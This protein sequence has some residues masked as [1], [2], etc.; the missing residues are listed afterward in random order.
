MRMRIVP[1]LLLLMAV[2]PPSI[3]ARADDWTS[4]KE[5][6]KSA[7]DFASST[8]QLKKTIKDVDENSPLVM[9]I[10][11]LSKLAAQ[12]DD[13]VAKGAVYED[14]KKDFRKIE[15]GYA[16]FEAGLKKDHDIHH[17]IPVVN[18]AKKAKAS[19]EQLQAHMSGRR[20]TDKSNPSISP[21][22]PKDNS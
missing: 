14:A 15:S 9:E 18:A 4:P 2:G 20:P 21:I 3:T 5:V 11:S 1:S 19:F 6:A 10:A 7:H 17:E 8:E 13:S 12:L 22:S 16:H